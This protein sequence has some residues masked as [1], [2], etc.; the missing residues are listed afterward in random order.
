MAK[1]ASF[2]DTDLLK[3]RAI[4]EQF[5]QFLKNGSLYQKHSFEILPDEFAQV[6]INMVHLDCSCSER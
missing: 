4:R 1:D 2:N 5:S 3:Q 6:R